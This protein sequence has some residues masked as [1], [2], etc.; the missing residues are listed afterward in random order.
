MRHLPIV[1]SAGLASVGLL[2][3]SGAAHANHAA[4]ADPIATATSKRR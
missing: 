2:A 1:L 4:T 3:V